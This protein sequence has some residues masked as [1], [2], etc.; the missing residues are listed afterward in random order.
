M[1]LRNSA[2]QVR[3]IIIFIIIIISIS[4]LAEIPLETVSLSLQPEFLDVYNTIT[5]GDWFSRNLY[6][7][8]NGSSN[9]QWN[10]VYWVR[11]GQ[12]QL[13]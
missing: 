7:I 12:D 13:S 4:D 6:M 10:E 1:F 11:L 5:K 9:L 2:I 8:Q 3:F